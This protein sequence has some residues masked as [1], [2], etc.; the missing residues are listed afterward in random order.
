MNQASPASQANF[1]QSTGGFFQDIILQEE[2]GPRR[3]MSP[4]AHLDIPSHVEPYEW[5]NQVKMALAGAGLRTQVHVQQREQEG[6][7][8]QGV[9]VFH[10]ELNAKG[11]G[12]VHPDYD[13]YCS[14]ST[15]I[16]PKFPTP[17]PYHL[18]AQ[19]QAEPVTK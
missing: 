3:V 10:H 12:T 9:I 16:M 5:S 14:K 17:L 7:T 8:H 6:A 13:E 11:D 2:D 1:Q 18:R 19:I 15:A 4:R